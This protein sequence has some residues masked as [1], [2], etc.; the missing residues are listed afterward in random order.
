MEKLQDLNLMVAEAKKMANTF[1]AFERI[2]RVLELVQSASKVLVDLGKQEQKKNAELADL[3]QQ[4]KSA[5][6]SVDKA[7]AALKKKNDELKKV[8]DTV[9][10]ERKE[11]LKAVDI[12][13][14]ERRSAAE[15]D[16]LKQELDL[17]ARVDAKKSELEDLNSQ[18]AAAQAAHEA[19]V[20]QYA[21][22]E[23]AA[24]RRALDA[25]KNLE[26]IKKSLFGE[27]S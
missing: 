26:Q 21:Q 19:R 5:K 20:S 9:D 11:L 15:K 10:S 17:K 13:I 8:S 6:D 24:Q 7:K 12:E 3:D 23:A 18:I 14:A 4:L 16:L 27:T 22:S 25:E 2:P 1:R